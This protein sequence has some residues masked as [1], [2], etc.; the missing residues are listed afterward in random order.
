MQMGIHKIKVQM[1]GGVEWCV[2]G[3]GQT[4]GWIWRVRVVFI[5]EA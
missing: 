3:G 5:A 2:H 4:D 1:Y